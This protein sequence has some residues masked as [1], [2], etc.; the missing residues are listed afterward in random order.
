METKLERVR[1]VLTR[2]EQ[3]SADDA[4]FLIEEIS[5][6]RDLLRHARYQTMQVKITASEPDDLVVNI[7][8]SEEAT[9]RA[10]IREVRRMWVR[11]HRA[12]MKGGE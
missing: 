4:W 3:I 6:Y 1:T 7:V 5:R 9:E 2:G 10:I 8:A 12:A 11:M